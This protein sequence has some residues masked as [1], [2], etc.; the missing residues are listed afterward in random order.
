VLRGKRTSTQEFVRSGSSAGWGESKLTPVW[1]IL[2]EYNQAWMAA[3]H[4]TQ[5]ISQGVLELDGLTELLAANKEDLVRKRAELI[6]YCRSVARM[7]VID[8]NRESY[9]REAIALGGLAEL[10]QQLSLRLASAAD[11]PVT[12]LMGQAPSGLNAT[13][14][15]EIRQFYDRCAG[16]RT[17]ELLPLL[18][19]VFL[20]MFCAAEGPTQGRIPEC[21]TVTFP[22]LW[23][24]TQLEEADLEKKHA[25][26]DHIRIEDGVLLP[27]E[28]TMSRY[29]G[30]Q[31]GHDISL[32]WEL[33]AAYKEAEEEAAEAA[34]PPPEETP[35]P[36]EG[37]PSEG[38]PEEEEEPTRPGG[39]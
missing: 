29:G 37:D 24:M 21:W 34:P 14:D 39:E 7:Y 10:L 25:E 6:D 19:R 16:Q 28:V 18:K 38:P 35:P 20:L 13:S 23:Q 2:R 31:Y 36:G 11:M 8:K 3:V 5:E 26:T 27:E 22:P 17:R 32:D 4:L 30:D 12:L 9:R 15:G 1:P 33:R